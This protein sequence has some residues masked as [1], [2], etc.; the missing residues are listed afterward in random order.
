MAMKQVLDIKDRMMDKEY[1]I[2]GQSGVYVEEDYN[3]TNNDFLLNADKS[4]RF[5]MVDLWQIGIYGSEN[6]NQTYDEETE[7]NIVTEEDVIKYTESIV[8]HI[9]DRLFDAIKESIIDE[10]EADEQ[11][12]IKL[13]R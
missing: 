1:T 4:N 6:C 10:I 8:K 13:V 2:V 7:L 3:K 11:E 9:N 5:I 12:T